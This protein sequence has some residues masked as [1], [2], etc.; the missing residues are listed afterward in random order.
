[1]AELRNTACLTVAERA[2]KGEINRVCFLGVM[3]KERTRS[4]MI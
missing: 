1:M 3:D 4:K 2:E